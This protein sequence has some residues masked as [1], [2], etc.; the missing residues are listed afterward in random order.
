M[1]KIESTL[2][3]IPA[4]VAQ[5]FG[6]IKSRLCILWQKIS[7]RIP[8]ISFASVKSFIFGFKWRILI[9]LVILYAGSKTYDYFYPPVPKAGKGGGPTTVSTIVVEKKD[10]PIVI[11]ATGTMVS[12]A[13]VDIRPM[14]T[15]TVAKIHVKDGQEVKAG[16]LLFTLDNRNDTANYERLKA[17]AEDAQKQYLRATE[18]VTKNFISKAGLE[19]S[20]ANAK[21]AQAA[22]RSAEVQLSF[23][24]IR[25][26]IDGRAGI[27]NVF[28][29]SLVQASNVVTTATSS[30]AT[31]SVGSMVT[32]TQLNPINVQFVIP[33]K[34]IP[35]L[36]ENQLDG[37]PVTVKVTVGDSGKKAYEGKVLV[38]DNQVDP[39]IAAV[40]VKAQIPNKSMSI[41]P[42]QFARVSIVANTLKDALSVPSEAIIINPRGRIVYIVDS[43][44]KAVAKP[45]KV[46][47]E[48]QGTSIVT[49]I[50][51]GD[52]VVVEGKQKLRPGSKVREAK[53]KNAAP[54]N[55]PATE[56]K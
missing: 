13:I 53:T 56:K 3:K 46:V 41:L 21:A 17:L 14:V 48:Y 5:V 51:A 24:S 26:P 9:V 7:H 10:I 47:Y 42:G 40:R 37:E 22:A 6:Y 44:G 23:D 29:G 39:S 15:N 25:S 12:N 20:L 2:N 45:V 50:E 52:K 38:I 30:T 34:D 54:Q 4:K 11:E 31:S 49:G 1:S 18:L 32:I 55:P 43:E 27:V 19:T 36:L 28:P 16:D 35:I 33:E 8:T